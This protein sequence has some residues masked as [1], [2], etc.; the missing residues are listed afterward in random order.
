MPRDTARAMSTEN[1]ALVREGFAAWERGDIDALVDGAHPDIEI[2]QPPEVPDSKTYRG[3]SGLAEAFAD[4]PK[5]WDG[6]RAELVE[7]IDVDDAQV[8]AV[9]RHYMRARDMDL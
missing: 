6:F 1:V 3:K 2:V 9:T 8:I 5:Q 4:W 7:V